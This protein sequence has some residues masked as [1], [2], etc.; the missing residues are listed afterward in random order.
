MSNPVDPSGSGSEGHQEGPLRAGWPGEVELDPI[1]GLP[2]SHP[3]PEDVAGIDPTSGLPLEA[4]EAT[5]HGTTH[6]GS[7]PS[8]W[9]SVAAGGGAS[10]SSE[11]SG[12]GGSWG[13]GNWGPGGPGGLGGPGGHPWGSTAAPPAWSGTR[14]RWTPTVVLVIVASLIGGLV[15][16][17]VERNSSGGQKTVV[18][19][20]HN[21]TSYIPRMSDPQSII[22]KVEPALVSIDTTAYVPVGGGLFGGAFGQQVVQGAGTGMVISP[23]GLVLTNNH[24]IDGATKITVT[25]YGQSAPRPATLVG[26][27]PSEDLAVIKIQGVSGLPTVTFADSSKVQVGDSVLAIGNALALGS[28]LTVTEG[29]VSALNRSENAGDNTGNSENLTG[30][31][32]TDAAINAGNSGGPLVNSS[33]QVIGM[34]TAVASSS[35]GNAPA[36]GIGFAIASNTIRAYLPKLE[37]GGV[38]ASN[39]AYMGVGVVDASSVAGQYGIPSSVSGAFVCSVVAGSPADAAGIQ[40]GEVITAFNGQSISSAQD[41]TNAVQAAT[42][43]QRVTVSLWSSGSTLEAHLTLGTEPSNLSGLP[44]AGQQLC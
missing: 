28:T 10:G 44:P 24:V 18:E 42:P 32:Q 3:R 37:R 8:S 22:A 7:A 33:A 43:G 25:L 13:P 29:I 20:F 1:S 4:L 34:N 30:L 9:A 15:G 19:T 6:R 26:A 12:G 35:P 14:G 39:K 31:I 38:V 2:I 41:L 40:A 23:D 17:L 21:N 11:P 16:G 27:D 36:E 5:E